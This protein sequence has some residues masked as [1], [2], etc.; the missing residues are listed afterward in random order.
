MTAQE[1]RDGFTLDDS[2]ETDCT[3]CG[4]FASVVQSPTLEHAICEPCARLALSLLEQVE[5]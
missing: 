3:F 5:P 1:E 2:R 4:T